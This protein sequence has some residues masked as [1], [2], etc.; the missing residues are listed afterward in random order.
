MYGMIRL[1]PMINAVT[2]G[3]LELYYTYYYVAIH[4]LAVTVVVTVVGRRVVRVVSVRSHCSTVSRKAFMVSQS[5]IGAT[6]QRML[7]I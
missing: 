1:G 4:H 7:R 3:V 2:F 5:E 6:S